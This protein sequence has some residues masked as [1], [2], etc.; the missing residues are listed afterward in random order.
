M[1]LEFL[2]QSRDSDFQGWQF[3]NDNAPNN[4]VRK[5]MIFVPEDIADCEHLRPGN[6][7]TEFF[8]VIRKRAACL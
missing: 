2:V 8:D 5:P 3:V 7:R 6:F 1:C 4:P